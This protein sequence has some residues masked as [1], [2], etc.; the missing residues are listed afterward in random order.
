M[1]GTIALLNLTF[2]LRVRSLNLT[3]NSLYVN[4]DMTTPKRHEPVVPVIT[5]LPIQRPKTLLQRLS[6]SI[7]HAL[8]S[9][10][11]SSSKNDL[12]DR[13][14]TAPGPFGKRAKK[15]AVAADTKQLLSPES[16]IVA[17]GES[18]EP[19]PYDPD[20]YHS[21]ASIEKRRCNFCGMRGPKIIPHEPCHACKT[22]GPGSH[23]TSAGTHRRRSAVD[24]RHLAHLAHSSDSVLLGPRPVTPERAAKRIGNP[25]RVSRLPPG[26]VRLPVPNAANTVPRRNPFER[27][28]SRLGMR[29]SAGVAYDIR[30]HDSHHTSM[31]S[32]LNKPTSPRLHHLPLL[33][34]SEKHPFVHRH[35][36]PKHAIALRAGSS[37]P[38]I[39]RSN[40]PRMSPRTN[41]TTDYSE[42]VYYGGRKPSLS[43]HLVDLKKPQT[44]TAMVKQV[45]ARKRASIDL[46]ASPLD[47]ALAESEVYKKRS[48]KQ[49]SSQPKRALVDSN[50]IS[51]TFGSQ[52]TGS[53]KIGDM[54]LELKGGG[55][56]ANR[57][58]LRG[59]SG[60]ES[61][62]TDT[63]AFKLKR[64]ILLCQ[65]CHRYHDES[66]D[67]L[68]P[69][70]IARMRQKMNGK[71]PLPAHLSRGAPSMTSSSS[72][73]RASLGA[74]A[75]PPVPTMATMSGPPKQ[76]YSSCLSLSSFFYRRP[77][78]PIN[79]PAPVTQ[80]QVLNPPFPQLR[81]GAES[82]DKIPSTLFW[83]A[84]GTGRKPISFSSWK[85]SRPKKRMGGLFGM[86]VFGDKYDQD[87]TMEAKV[88]GDVEIECSASVKVN[89]GNEAGAKEVDGGLATSSASSSSRSSAPSRAESAKEIATVAEEDVPEPVVE[90]VPREL[91]PPPGESADDV[92]LCSDALPVELNAN[93]PS[94]DVAPSPPAEA[95]DKAGDPVVVDEKKPQVA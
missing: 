17:A 12:I 43:S 44:T 20:S 13:S 91:T 31:E 90:S 70:R 3:R 21:L 75:V 89:V 51:M 56:D 69:A 94:D 34:H 54:R 30:L 45:T 39:D 49:T 42:T 95:K 48:P 15:T 16:E 25:P 7:V 47:A 60:Y 52:D 61:A 82:P 46:Y 66:D 85:Q 92:P 24:A 9:L 23:I 41:N 63:F 64:W 8:P 32:P 4:C 2:T 68:P 78:S 35:E 65:P 6:S 19:C 74:E 33:P 28:P 55:S 62:S 22:G 14:A 86:A 38:L 80:A 79:Q 84:G 57:P 87:Y 77:D 81:G 11:S 83:L 29:S 5:E 72:A 58:R 50:D 73:T 27:P 1:G 26:I 53:T 67:D 37:S 93:V 71:A 76:S 10:R 59:G 40:S 36:I 18:A 88:V